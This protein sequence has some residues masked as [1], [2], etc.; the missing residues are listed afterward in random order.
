MPR[1]PRP[2]TPPPARGPRRGRAPAG[3]LAPALAAAAALAGCQ[4]PVAA[5]LSEDEA[6]RVVVALD[7]GGVETAKE[8]DPQAEGR[9]R[10][11]VPREDAARAVAVLRDEELPPRAAPGVLDALGKSSLVPSAMAE[12]A[13]Y[14]AG[15]A[16]DL[17]RTLG[18]ID[19]VIAARVHL[20]VPE[21]GPLGD[22][23]ASAATASVLLKYR[24]ANPPV[25]VAAVQ[26]LV[27][28]AV[29]GLRV[30]DVAVVLLPR[31]AAP[32]PPERQLAHVGPLA[33][34]RGTMPYLR[35]LVALTLAVN[36]ALLASLGTLWA[37][38]RRAAR[39]PGPTQ[40]RP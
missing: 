2:P 14:V 12:R 32:S 33:V 30:P 36:L 22:K 9:F 4:A 37:R 34:T 25:D 35:G 11:L 29:A 17:E 19:G 38:L 16:G 5:G 40:A 26:H 13:Q 23:P 24:G 28:G 7:R 31:P 3:A 39:A 21:P 27:A 10:V 6:N 8:A 20:S 15:L 18:A 1:R